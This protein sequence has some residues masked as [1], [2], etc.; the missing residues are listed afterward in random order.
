MKKWVAVSKAAALASVMLVMVLGNVSCSQ[1][2]EVPVPLGE[3]E[4]PEFPG[5]Q[6]GDPIPAVFGDLSLPIPNVFPSRATLEGYI[7]DAGF[8][9]LLN[10]VRIESVELV[11]M[12]LEATQGSFNGLTR[13]A[14]TWKLAAV[15]GV[16]PDP[17]D[18]G[19][20]LSPTGTL[21][22]NI[23]LTPAATVNILDLVDNAATHDEGSNPELSIGVA[24]TV[25][26]P[27]PEWDFSMRIRITIRLF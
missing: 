9:W 11:E 7:E 26:N 12:R 10:I 8:G 1:S 18:L 21:G 20:A 4:F 22:T 14:F 25:P 5:L 19:T 3:S 17:V 13:L 16:T 27:L 6:P 15:G 24:G 2:F 23:T